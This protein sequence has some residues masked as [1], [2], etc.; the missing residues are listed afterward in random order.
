MP[1]ASDRP[2]G[3]EL[4]V[5]LDMDPIELRLR[6]N[7]AAPPGKDLQWSSKHLDECFR[8]GAARFGW[9]NRAPRGRTDGDWLVGVGTATAM[10]RALRFPATV[11]ISLRADDTAVVATSGADPGTAC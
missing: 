2:A 5:A 7:S 6:N 11:E 1:L 10:F 4:A 9:A 3:D 8:I